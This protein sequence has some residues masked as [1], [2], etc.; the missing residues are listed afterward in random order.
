MSD[1]V[2]ASDSENAPIPSKRYL[3]IG[4]VGEVFDLKPHVLRYWEQEFAQ[5]RPS[6]RRGNRR[7]YQREDVLLIRRIKQLLYQQG[8]TIEGARQ[9]LSNEHTKNQSSNSSNQ[10]KNQEING[11]IQNAV[12]G[13]EDVMNK[14]K[15]G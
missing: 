12:S 2:S 15:K 6:K 9:Q 1:E 5:L 7:Y 10:S 4:E 8:F 13:L 11:A 3:T 14:L